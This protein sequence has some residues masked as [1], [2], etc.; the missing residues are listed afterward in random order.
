MTDTNRGQT[1]RL[2]GYPE[3]ARLLIVN[4]DDFGM[5]HSNIAATMRAIREGIVT[6][7][8]LMTPCPWAPLAMTL[9]KANPDIP[10]GVHLTIV[11][12][13]DAYR[14][15]P[16]AS[17][18]RVPSLLDEAGYF[19][20]NSCRDDLLAQAKLDEIEIEY[21]AQIATVLGAGLA[22]TH[23]DW[24][25]LAD[26]GRDDIFDLTFALAKEFG[27]A[28]RV[29][30]PRSRDA[31][32]AAGKPPNDYGTLDSYSLPTAGKDEQY[33]ALLRTLPAGLSEWAVHPGL[34]DG[35]AQAMEP[36]GW[37]VRK[38]DFD[39]VISPEARRLIAEE[40]I[41][42]LDYRPLQ[43]LWRASA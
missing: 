5:C 6:S 34:G 3:D 21:R 38:A 2:L 30:F 37:P 43:T 41:T 8:T 25:C 1:N 4:A 11:S 36:D 17:K 35:E 33:A 23:L 28:V 7:T 15:G 31:C 24:H 40:S 27:L 10:F 22:P 26:G 12:E 20:R 13:H 42:L 32:Q 19:F 9:L 18:D 14:W 39:F 16:V 29:H